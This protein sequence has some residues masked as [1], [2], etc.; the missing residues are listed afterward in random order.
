MGGHDREM[1]SAYHKD[2]RRSHRD[3]C[4]VRTIFA[5]YNLQ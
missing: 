1:E 2:Q 5:I 3:V 4:R